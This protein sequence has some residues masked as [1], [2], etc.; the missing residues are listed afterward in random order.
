[1]RKMGGELA[2]AGDVIG[3]S[4]VNKAVGGKSKG[5]ICSPHFFGGRN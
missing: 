2:G 5:N 1:M 3:P 4:K